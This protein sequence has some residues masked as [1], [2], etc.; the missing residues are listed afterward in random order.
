LR[1]ERL[2]ALLE[3]RGAIMPP[4]DKKPAPLEGKRPSSP[5]TKVDGKRGNKKMDVD[6]GA[7]GEQVTDDMKILAA[8]KSAATSKLLDLCNLGLNGIPQEVWK[9]CIE[10]DEPEPLIPVV[11][12]LQL[13]SNKLTDFEGWDRLAHITDLSLDRCNLI[14]SLPDSVYALTNLTRL[15]ISSN[16]LRNLKQIAACQRLV[17]LNA[18]DNELQSLPP[19]IGTLTELKTLEV[20]FNQ[21]V[22]LPGEVS[23]CAALVS[24]RAR[25]NELKT[26]PLTISKL[27][28]LEVL[29]IDKNPLIRL[30]YCVAS[31]PL[32]QITYDIE[33][34]QVLS[35]LALLVQKYKH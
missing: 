29:M 23:A 3:R 11:K 24:I 4:K 30:P 1:E 10:A 27:W 16:K 8:L 2:S 14:E 9:Y 25:G 19:S 33:L 5:P 15:N 18:S 28:T 21:L 7:G 35:L 12:Q 6:V 34:L 22:T 20:S 26:L 32:R 17:D 13:S 31:M